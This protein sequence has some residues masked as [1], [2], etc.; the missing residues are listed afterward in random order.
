MR[1]KKREGQIEEY[2]RSKLLVSLLWSSDHLDE[3]DVAFAL[4]DTVEVR[5]LRSLTPESDQISSQFIAETV[6]DVLKRF[7]LKSF[8]KYVT[9][10]EDSLE[11]RDLQALLKNSRD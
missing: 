1:V 10:R 8:I 5:L 7:D 6:Q 11:R 9:N 4:A 3:A 2:Q